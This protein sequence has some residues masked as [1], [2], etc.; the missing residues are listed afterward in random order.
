MI[1]DIT[2]MQKMTLNE[3]D[4]LVITVDTGNMPR[5]AAQQ[6]MD[7]VLT[8]AKVYFFSTEICVVPKGVESDDPGLPTIGQKQG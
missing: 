2:K 7:Q 3:G 1:D 8:A 5:N 4:V 6:Y